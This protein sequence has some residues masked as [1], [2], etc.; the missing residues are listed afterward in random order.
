MA[1]GMDLPSSSERNEKSLPSEIRTA[2]EMK[3]HSKIRTAYEM[4]LLWEIRTAMKILSPG[5]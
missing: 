1:Y 4:N 3:L 2:Y 5:M